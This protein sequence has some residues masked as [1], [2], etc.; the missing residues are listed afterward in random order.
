MRQTEKNYYLGLNGS[1]E[2]VEGGKDKVEKCAKLVQ[3]RLVCGELG[4]DGKGE[5]GCAISL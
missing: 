1:F 2:D 4:V 3:R 5:E